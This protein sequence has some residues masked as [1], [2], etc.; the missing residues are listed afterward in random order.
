MTGDPSSHLQSPSTFLS[1][2]PSQYTRGDPWAL[3]TKSCKYKYHSAVSSSTYTLLVSH[4]FRACECHPST[5]PKSPWHTEQDQNLPPTW[6]PA[7]G[8][9]ML[10]SRKTYEPLC[11]SV[12]ASVKWDNSSYLL[13]ELLR[14]LNGLICIKNSKQCLTCCKSCDILFHGS[15]VDF[16]RCVSFSCTTVN[17]LYVYI[18]PFPLEP[19]SHHL[20][21]TLHRAVSWAPWA[22]CAVQ[23]LP[24]S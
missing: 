11:A 22:P 15:I 10:L 8:I 2:S 17:Q 23:Q 5:H 16:Q 14:G 19:P 18:Y 6:A 7:V 9:V 4:I 21:P 3:A 12:S 20:H 13:I 24:T 1:F